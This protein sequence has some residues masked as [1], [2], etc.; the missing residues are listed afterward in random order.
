MEQIK[1]RAPTA[2]TVTVEPTVAPA[3]TH[4]AW[5]YGLADMQLGFTGP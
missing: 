3:Y 2:A 1:A 4:L 5:K